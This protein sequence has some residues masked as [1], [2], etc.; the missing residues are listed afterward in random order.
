MLE[1]EHLDRDLYRGIHTVDARDRTSLFGGQVMAQALRAAGLTVPEDRYPHSLHG[2]FLRPGR[3]DLPVILHVDRDRDGRSFSARHVAAVQDGQVIFSMLAS[4]HGDEPG[5]TLDGVPTLASP[6]PDRGEPMVWNALFE[7]HDLDVEPTPGAMTPH[8][9]W[10]RA[11]EPVPPEDRLLQACGLTYASD[12]GSGFETVDEPG[13]PKGGPSI[14]HALWFQAPIR[15]DEWLL[16][17]LWPTKVG[18]ARGVYFGSM[19]AADG[20]L[21]ATLAQETLLRADP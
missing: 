15:I 11:L 9:R 10:V 17:E 21:G 5:G 13:I 6:P 3:A 7:S 20:R 19:R 1:L 2:Y 16:I 8:R 12:F 18:G 14:D 4:F